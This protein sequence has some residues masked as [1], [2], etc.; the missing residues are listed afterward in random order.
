MRTPRSRL[1]APKNEPPH[2]LSP[3]RLSAGSLVGLIR[4]F[5]RAAIR[6]D[7]FQRTGIERSFRPPAARP[8]G[9][10]ARALANRRSRCCRGRARRVPPRR[11][12]SARTTALDG[13]LTGT[14][15]LGF[16]LS[17]WASALGHQPY[18]IR[19]SSLSRNLPMIIDIRSTK[20]PDRPCCSHQC[21]N[22]NHFHCFFAGSRRVTREG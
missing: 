19:C 22:C 2:R 21:P 7:R 17:D 3:D 18:L 9:P 16:G 5:Q 11:A 4:E 20:G 10:T 8:S 6:A 13:G 14:P 12:R 15:S 1:T